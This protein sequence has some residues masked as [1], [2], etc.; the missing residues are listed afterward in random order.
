MWY[1]YLNEYKWWLVGLLLLITSL[2]IF[3]TK[4]GPYPFEYGEGTD[5]VRPYIWYFEGKDLVIGIYNPYGVDCVY[6]GIELNKFSKVKVPVNISSDTPVTVNI[7]IE[8]EK[9]T[10][11][12]VVKTVKLS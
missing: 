3:F 5:T 8:C 4:Q 11:T 7:N 12:V 6:T 1:Y 10:H 9:S 2:V